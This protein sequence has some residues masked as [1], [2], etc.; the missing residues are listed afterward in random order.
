[1]SSASNDRPASTPRRAVPRGAEAMQELRRLLVQPEQHR[2]DDLEEQVEHISVDAE[3]LSQILPE[4]VRR[5]SQRDHHLAKALAPTLTDAF[6]D[7]IRRNP[8][9]LVDVIAPIMGPAI[10]R[11]IRQAISSM[12]ESLNQTLE[13]SFSWKGLQWRM[14]AMRTGKPFAEVVLLHT[15][16]YRIEQVLLIHRDSGL[17]L[18]QASTSADREKDA[19]LVSGMLTAIRD[20]VRDSFGGNSADML[21]AM[22]VGDRTVWVEDGPEAVLAVAFRGYPPQELRERLIETLEQIHVDYREPLASFA[23]DDT[24]MQPAEELLEPLLVAEYRATNRRKGLSVGRIIGWAIPL[25]LIGAIGWWLFQLVQDRYWTRRLSTA[26]DLPPSVQL[27]YDHG[28]VTI[29]GEARHEWLERVSE[30]TSRFPQIQHWD[31]AQVKD[32]DSDWLQFLKQ[33]RDEP[34]VVVTESGRDSA[35][36]FVRGLRDPLARDPEKLLANQTAVQD[37]VRME[38]APYECPDD[39]F[40]TWRATAALQPPHGAEI[41]VAEGKLLL[42]GTAPI[43]F[44]SR[45]R[46]LAELTLPQRSTDETQLTITYPAWQQWLDV[47]RELA[48]VEIVSAEIR[49]DEYFFE[50]KR[51][52]LVHDPHQLLDG[53]AVDRSKLH[54]QWQSYYCLDESFVRQRLDAAIKLPSTVWVDYQGGKLTFTGAASHGWTKYAQEK[55]S[56]TSGL[57]AFDLSQ[58]REPESVRKPSLREQLSAIVIE[59]GREDTYVLSASKQQLDDA[60]QV[61]RQ[62]IAVAERNRVQV[63]IEVRG[64]GVASPGDATGELLGTNWAE[65]V[66]GHLIDRGIPTRW[67]RPIA[68]RSTAEQRTTSSQTPP[69]SVTFHIV[70]DGH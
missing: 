11:S 33:L 66:T 70:N 8:Q 41:R 49:D 29:T 35:G 37:G 45:A 7:S 46:T 27:S 31:W 23:G 30:R 32:R 6:Q 20:F 2:L 39:A 5:G 69:R 57:P 53:P 44:V 22:Q 48:G 17:L 50:G 55:L 56:N 59:A 19:D 13:H 10:R 43:E 54:L 62:I 58:V 51:D 67:L 15:L 64:R 14:E 9:G 28:T 60:A 25:L 12:V 4:A 42:V 40:E 36:Y 38:F 63:R 18:A 52:P 68:E 16:I 47:V 26:L 34:G 3:K 24:A 65:Q 1:M 61:I 21:D